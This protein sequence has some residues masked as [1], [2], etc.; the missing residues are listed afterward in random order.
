MVP[1]DNVD[2]YLHLFFSDMARDFDN[3]GIIDFWTNSRD[4][5]LESN[6]EKTS[7]SVDT[8]NRRILMSFC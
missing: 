8:S 2:T 6:D 5:E 3:T 1:I 7:E 4:T